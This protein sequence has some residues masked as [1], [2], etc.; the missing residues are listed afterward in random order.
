MNINIK[1][2]VLTIASIFVALGV[3][4]FIGFMLDGQK[5]FSEQQTAIINELE[6]KFKDLQAENANLKNTVQEL[7]KEINYYNQY[8]QIIFPELVANRLTGVKVAIIE[9]T[10]E[11]IFSGMRNALLKAGATIESITIIKEGFDAGDE[12]EV[13]NLINFLSN[14]Y[15]VS[16]DPK[17]LNEFVSQKLAHAIVTGQDVDLINYLKSNGYIDFTGMPGNVDF[18]I[19][20]GGSNN[21]EN[22]VNYIDVP[23]IKEVKLLNIPIV[24]V[25]QSD[26]KY[27]YMEAYKKQHIS[28]IDNV[29]SIIG[30]TSLI[31]VMEGKEGNYGV[32]QEAMS[33]M[34]DSF[35]NTSNITQKR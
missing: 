16:I 33:L 28:T 31:M 2:Y 27:S 20:A 7:N 8:H 1:Y 13:Q 5:I 19:I 4:I 26:A 32:K 3:G 25:E 35:G 30:Q 22:N 29:D 24:G 34:P 15:G 14:K 6:Q 23:I 9:T 11:F 10:N 21:K 17:H 12:L 18:V